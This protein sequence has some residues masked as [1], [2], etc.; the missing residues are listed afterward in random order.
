MS[1]T[2]PSVRAAVRVLNQRSC[3]SGSIVGHYRGGSL[4]L[5]NA[6]V[7]GT[8]IGRRVTI[9]V[10]SL[11][12]RRLTGTVIRAAYSSQYSADW[13]LIHIPQFQEVEPV[14]LSMAAPHKV[15]SMY[16]K[17]FPNC[18]QHAG[19][20]IAQIAEISNGV[21][22][23]LP[24]AISGQSGSGVWSDIDH[25]QKALLAWSIKRGNKWYGAGQ[26][27]SE[28]YR[29]NRML[30]RGDNL[31]GHERLPEMKE[32]TDDYDFSEIDTVVDA[33]DPIV[34][35]GFHAG[36]IERGIQDFPIWAEEEE[37]IDEP[38]NGSTRWQQ[39]VAA[40]VTKIREFAD[41]IL[42]QFETLNPNTDPNK[43]RRNIDEFF[44]L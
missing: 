3:G 31:V 25:Q 21:M 33:D 42:K 22:L 8:K 7:A 44:G 27:T 37:P 10:E 41:D 14:Y 32:L 16:T 5:T 36:F 9:E 43:G 13:A 12:M 23:W 30:I 34:E 28:I 18:R 2:G 1:S 38:N 26:L 35:D 6:H 4:V 24:D 17:G 20:D 40:K 29:Q 19:T 39:Q 11:N 15:E